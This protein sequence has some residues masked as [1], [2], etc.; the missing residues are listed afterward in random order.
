MAVPYRMTFRHRPSGGTPVAVRGV[1]VFRVEAGLIAHRVDYWDS[2][3]VGRQLA[4]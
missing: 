4:G 2:G 1:F 3:E